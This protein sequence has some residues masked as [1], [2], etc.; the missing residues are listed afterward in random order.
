MAITR[1]T[2]AANTWHEITPGISRTQITH[3]QGKGSV[4]YTEAAST[5]TTPYDE[6]VPVNNTS[7]IGD[8]IYFTDVGSNSV[9]LYPIAIDASLT[10]TTS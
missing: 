1:Q 10:V 9:W 6:T 2:Y 8:N 3:N 5:P 7:N 4:V